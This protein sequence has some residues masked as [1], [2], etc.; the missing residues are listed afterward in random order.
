MTD[1]QYT[2]RAVVGIASIGIGSSLAGCTDIYRDI[3]ASTGDSDDASS[4]GEGQGDNGGSGGNDG[5]G[6]NNG[7]GDGSNDGGNGGSDPS[8]PDEPWEE[9]EP[10]NG[11]IDEGDF[12]DRINDVDII[13]TIENGDGYADFDVQVGANSWMKDVDPEPDEPGEP[14]FA[15]KINDVLVTRS[16]TVAYRKQGSWE[17]DIP[18]GA[19]EQFDAGEL[20]VKILLLEADK[21]RDDLFGRWTGTVTYQP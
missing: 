20:E 13:N 12:D 3:G 19:L 15:V 4:G 10:I 6:S 14:Y 11:P 8:V 2:R 16:D 7:G 18:T 1:K 21:S 9:P 5:G 17:L